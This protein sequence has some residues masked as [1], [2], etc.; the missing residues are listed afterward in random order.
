M[1]TVWGAQ[2]PPDSRD[3]R[4]P[5]VTQE[6]RRVP[7]LPTTTYLST[8]A[9]RLGSRS[10]PSTGS[11]SPQS[12]VQPPKRA[13]IFPLLLFPLECLYWAGFHLS[14]TEKKRRSRKKI[15]KKNSPPASLPFSLRPSG[16]LSCRRCADQYSERTEAQTSSL[17][18]Q[19]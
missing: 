18:F 3:F 2:L 10:L 12:R 1:W 6:L 5:R 11:A 19:L 16:T 15:E 17:L 7:A 14:I 9:P 13:N 8:A 4:R